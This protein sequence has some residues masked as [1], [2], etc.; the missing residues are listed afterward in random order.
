MHER[1]IGS[2]SSLIL[3]ASR[4]TASNVFHEDEIMQRR[5]EEKNRIIENLSKLFQGIKERE[6]EKTKNTNILETLKMRV[7]KRFLKNVAISVQNIH[8]RLVDTTSFVDTPFA[9]GIS[10]Q[11]I[12]I[13]HARANGDHKSSGEDAVSSTPL[14]STSRD[15]A[16]EHT[17]SRTLTLDGLLV[18]IYMGHGVTSEMLFDPSCNLAEFK[19]A[20]ADIFRVAARTYVVRLL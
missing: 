18:Y 7:L 2:F 3:F 20:M 17:M 19:F 15:S 16:D 9:L 14:S 11:R 8:I 12:S 6:K 13:P 10:L 4:S 5:E 1:C